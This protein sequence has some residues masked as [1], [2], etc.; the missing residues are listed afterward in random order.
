M[1][2]LLLDIAY[3]TDAQYDQSHTRMLQEGYGS[4]TDMPTSV[5]HISAAHM[6][7]MS[8]KPTALLTVHKQF[9]RQYLIAQ[10]YSVLLPTVLLL[11]RCVSA[12]TVQH[13]TAH[14]A[15]LL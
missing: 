5:L 10:V 9:D 14:A 6:L 12:A 4:K 13:S 1:S 2:L 8:L 3:C 15:V 7:H 11:L